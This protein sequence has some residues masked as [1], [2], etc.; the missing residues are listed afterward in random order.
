LKAINSVAKAFSMAHHTLKKNL[1]FI[2]K[3]IEINVN[4]FKYLKKN[5]K[6]NVDI[7]KYAVSHGLSLRHHMNNSDSVSHVI[8]CMIENDDNSELF[9]E[10]VKNTGI[11]LAYASNRIKNNKIIVH[12][13]IKND[14]KA[15]E[16]ASN[17]L[18]NNVDFI[19]SVVHYNAPI[20]LKYIAP[21]LYENR[22]IMSVA[23]EEYKYSATFMSLGELKT[24]YDNT[25]HIM[26]YTYKE[27]HEMMWKEGGIGQGLME[28]FYH[29]SRI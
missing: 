17:Q 16:Y 2:Y 15:M 14:V 8:H 13:A 29:P 12:E 3:A 21:H 9:I 25:G 26:Y 28:Y 24:E 20:M 19:L 27:L 6:Y 4:C 11:S 5:Q 23:I 18:K 10:L 7:F 22:K 1:E